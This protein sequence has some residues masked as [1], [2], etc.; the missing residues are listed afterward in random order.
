MRLG[1]TDDSPMRIVAVE[2]VV[3]IFVLVVVAA[4]VVVVRG[5]LAESLHSIVIHVARDGT[6]AGVD[7]RT[8]LHLLRVHCLPERVH[9]MVLVHFRSARGTVVFLT[10]ASL[11]FPSCNQIM[12]R[13]LKT[14]PLEIDFSFKNVFFESF[15]VRR[16]QIPSLEFPR[17]FVSIY[18]ISRLPERAF[19]KV[20]HF[21][22][23][24]EWSGR[25]LI[26]QTPQNDSSSPEMSRFRMLFYVLWYL[27]EF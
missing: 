2:A 1:S 9:G 15:S 22:S 24:F 6:A 7:V 25:E 18:L 19:N 10:Q 26:A 11:V 12:K 8:S 16:N 27:S 4:A 5:L 20:H 17:S 21:S 23:E 3:E 13:K 14:L